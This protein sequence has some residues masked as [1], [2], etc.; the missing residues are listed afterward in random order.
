VLARTLEHGSIAERRIVLLELVEQIRV[1]PDHFEIVLK[2]NIAGS[3][4][5]A[6]WQPPI[7]VPRSDL[8]TAGPRAIVLSGNH[9]PTPPKA[10][11]D[12]NSIARGFGWFEDLTTGRATSAQAIA[13]RDG[14]TDSYVCRLINR[15]LTF[16]EL[17][18]RVG[19]NF[20]R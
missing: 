6:V 18:D 13:Q 17:P 8:R 7:I 12:M 14:V 4:E 5:N 11:S 15:A 10:L 20:A 1:T 2:P 19:E 3:V 16:C 9:S